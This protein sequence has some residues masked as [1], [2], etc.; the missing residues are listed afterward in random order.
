M[1]PSTINHYHHYH[2]GKRAMHTIFICL[3]ECIYWEMWVL[4]CVDKS[5]VCISIPAKCA[6]L[7]FSVCLQVSPCMLWPLHVY[8]CVSVCVSLII[9]EERRKPCH[10]SNKGY[11]YHL[12]GS[13]PLETPPLMTL[14][15]KTGVCGWLY[16]MCITCI[17]LNI[18]QVKIHVTV[19]K[20][21]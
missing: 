8:L 15:Q 10:H 14:F 12:P 9:L 3:A 18:S 19:L 20:H 17:C 11:L 4:L 16:S 6:G 7:C 13:K 21:R 2:L 1:K 5:Y